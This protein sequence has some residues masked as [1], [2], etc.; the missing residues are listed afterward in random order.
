[1]S[2]TKTRRW[3]RWLFRAAVTAE[4]VLAFAQAVLA[5][6]FLAGHYDF[7]AM[8]KEN[9]T[10]TGITAVV[11]GLCAVLLWRPGRGPWWPIPVS[12]GLFGVEAGQIVLG[13]SRILAV[14]IP[15]GVLIIAGILFLLVW[16]WRKPAE[17]TS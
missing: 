11:L 12:I 13:Y 5:G 17:A 15:L 3:P 1:M 8:H 6:G 2:T 14:H 4:A 16:A 10:R 9:A 7:L